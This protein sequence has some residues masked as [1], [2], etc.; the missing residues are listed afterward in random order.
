MAVLVGLTMSDRESDFRGPKEVLIQEVGRRLNR[1]GVVMAVDLG[2]DDPKWLKLS[3]ERRAKVARKSSPELTAI[4]RLALNITENRRKLDPGAWNIW[5]KGVDL[6]FECISEE[7][8]PHL[9]LEYTASVDYVVT[10]PDGTFHDGDSTASGAPYQLHELEFLDLQ[11]KAEAVTRGVLRIL[12]E[13]KILSEEVAV[14][15]QTAA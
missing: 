13:K 10:D 5:F 11:D 3:R 1:T 8:G 9:K 2:H 4:V 7:E 14:P 12:R 15:V 6:M